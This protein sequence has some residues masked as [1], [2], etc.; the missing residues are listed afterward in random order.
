MKKI[1][2]NFS[3]GKSPTFRLD[4]T[5]FIFIEIVRK[6]TL[7]ICIL[8]KIRLI[9]YIATVSHILFIFYF[10][11]WVHFLA[12]KYP[13]GIYKLM[14]LKPH[15]DCGDSMKVLVC[16]L[17]ECFSLQFDNDVLAKYLYKFCIDAVFTLLYHQSKGR[18]FLA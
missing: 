10:S 15:A 5:H 8:I 11:S 4:I 3:E 2:K 1:K 9:K 18:A 12:S 14:L 13:A 16:L 7:S 17:N 6:V